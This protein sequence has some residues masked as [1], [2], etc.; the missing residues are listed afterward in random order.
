V[1][2]QPATIRGVGAVLI[3]YDAKGVEIARSYGDQMGLGINVVSSST[4]DARIGVRDRQGRIVTVEL[5]FERDGGAN[6]QIIRAPQRI[7]RVWHEQLPVA[8]VKQGRVAT[9]AVTAITGGEPIATETALLQ[10]PF[11]HDRAAVFLRGFRINFDDGQPHPTGMIHAAL[12]DDK[13]RSLT[14]TIIKASPG[15]YFSFRAAGGFF[16]GNNTTHSPASTAIIHYAAVS[17]NS[18]E[19]EIYDRPLEWDFDLGNA[20][21]GTST[22]TATDPM[23]DRLVGTASDTLDRLKETE[24]LRGGLAHLPQALQWHGDNDDVDVLLWGGSSFLW[25][26]LNWA[27]QTVGLSRI[28]NLQGNIAVGFDGAGYRDFYGSSTVLTG[29]SILSVPQSHPD[30]TAMGAWNARPIQLVF[31]QQ[32][33]PDRTSLGFYKEAWHALRNDRLSFPVFAEAAAVSLGTF[34]AEPGGEIREIDV[35]AHAANYTNGLLDWEVGGSTSDSA[36]GNPVTRKLAVIPEFFAVRALAEFA[37]PKLSVVALAFDAYDGGINQKCFYDGD[38][39]NVGTG[40]A[41]IT[42]IRPG[43]LSGGV[44][45]A[46]LRVDYSFVWRSEPEMSLAEMRNRLP[47]Q[48]RPG[49]KLIVR[50]RYNGLPNSAAAK[51]LIEDPALSFVTADP[52]VARA[53]ISVARVDHGTPAGRWSP[54]KLRFSGAQMVGASDPQASLVSTGTAPL[55]V[56]GATSNDPQFAVKPAPGATYLGPYVVQYRATV[57]GLLLGDIRADTNA[58]IIDLDLEGFTSP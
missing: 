32:N 8:T 9:K 28:F 11:N 19:T 7:F 20:D 26:S 48:L 13:H 47:V 27:G 3:G 45:P 21:T 25:G 35:E 51:R 17:W 54:T 29:R 18:R 22:A 52:A 38:V 58:G 10:M 57:P 15:S 6:A 30:F 23:S 16:S 36:A 37:Q 33:P 53:M 40:D 1:P 42:E 56:Y 46:D 2:E 4:T 34:R 55:I 5:R 39:T 50:G 49:E 12:L 31:T 41:L 24:R 44:I 14:G 43:T